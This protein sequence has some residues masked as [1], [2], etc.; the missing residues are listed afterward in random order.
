MVNKNTKETGIEM[1]NKILAKVNGKE[2]TQNDM[3]MLLHTL[4]QQR[5]AQFNSEEGRKHV[6]NELI[7]QNLFLMDARENKV[8]ETDMFQ[9]ELE[10]MID[11]LMIQFRIN[12]VMGSVKVTDDE[13]KDYYEVHKDHYNKQESVTA[14][15]IL[16]ATEDECKKI[17]EQIAAGEVTFEEAAQ[18]HS[19]CPSKQNG[20][21]LGNFTR[22]R[23][24]PEFD[25][26]AFEMEAGEVSDPIQTQFGYHL[27]KVTEKTAPEAQDFDDVKEHVFN[28]LM[29]DRQKEAYISKLE[30]LKKQYTIEVL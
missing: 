10:K 11:S 15:H 12:Q 27:I 18:S 19:T 25:K 8:D 3:N 28:H 4:G 17:K 21:S 13:L 30:E 22:G 2:I 29:Q 9:K 16:V 26:A 1:E 20:G 14:S 6:L 24:V 7:H 5:A 23:M